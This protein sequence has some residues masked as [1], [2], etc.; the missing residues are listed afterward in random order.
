MQAGGERELDRIED[1]MWDHRRV[2]ASADFWGISEYH[3]DSIKA[4]IVL[5]ELDAKGVT[6][7]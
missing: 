1:G 5:G 3:R 7:I 4:H 2:V 6:G